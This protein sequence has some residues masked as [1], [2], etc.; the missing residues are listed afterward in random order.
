MTPPRQATIQTVNSFSN[1]STTALSFSVP[2]NGQNKT[3]VIWALSTTNPGKNDPATNLFQ[4]TFRGLEFFNLDQ[5]YDGTVVR[6]PSP[7]P[8]SSKTVRPDGRA[9]FVLIAHIVCGAIA[10]MMVLPGGVVVPRITRGL[11]TS[12]WWFQFHAINQGL[13][14]LALVCAAYG[15]ARSFGGP[16][17]TRHRKTGTALFALIILQTVLGVFSHWFHPGPRLKRFTFVTKRGRGPSNFLH[18]VFGI[19]CVAV[20]WGA[21]WTGECGLQ[22]RWRDWVSFELSLP[23]MSVLSVSPVARLH[24]Y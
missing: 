16:I 23:H 21:A 18:V 20:G 24:P 19:I 5:P 14:S 15:I 2:S 11:T 22:R 17:D 13:T 10:V 4:H 3:S 12:R 8:I 9:A 6:A 1:S 7:F